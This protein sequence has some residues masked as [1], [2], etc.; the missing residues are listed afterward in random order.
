MHQ[1]PRRRGPVAP[2]APSPRG[3]YLSDAPD[4]TVALS[5][6][7]HRGTCRARFEIDSRD[8]PRVR[9]VVRTFAESYLDVLDPGLRV[10]R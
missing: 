3:V 5:I 2:P 6:R 1:S 10:L 7:D 8:W 9:R 4:G